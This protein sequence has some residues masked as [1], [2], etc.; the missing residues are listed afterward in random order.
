MTDTAR[1]EYTH[2]DIR[3]TYKKGVI[4]AF[5][6]KWTGQPVHIRALRK[7]SPHFK[8]QITSIS[9]LGFNRS[10]MYAID[11]EAL[12]IQPLS[13]IKSDFPVTFKIQ[14]L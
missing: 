5:V 11:D 1:G 2:E 9:V 6:M 12:K 13:G 4:Y 7:G 14:L 10:V 8:G 3:F